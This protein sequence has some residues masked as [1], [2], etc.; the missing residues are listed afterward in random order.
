M[1]TRND[2]QAIPPEAM[3]ALPLL[4]HRLGSSLVAVYLHGSAVAEGL[5]RWSD[6]DL[7]GVVSQPLPASVRGALSA[8]LM[9]VSGLY[10]FDPMGRRPLEV[11][12]I[13]SADLERMP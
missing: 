13:R 10:P 8:E 1:D 7:L 4:R 2:K 6:V 5:R 11:I 12:V 3:K 9:T